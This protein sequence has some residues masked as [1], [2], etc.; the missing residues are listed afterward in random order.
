MALAL[1]I[2]AF[3]VVI[4]AVI[5]AFLM[6]GRQANDEAPKSEPSDFVV[7]SSRG[8]FAFR[9]VDESPSE[10]KARVARDDAQVLAEERARSERPGPPSADSGHR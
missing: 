8:G 1:G 5:A 6:A 3:V 7:P 10:F 4:G 9:Q 2:V